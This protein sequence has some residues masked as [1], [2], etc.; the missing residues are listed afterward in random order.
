M[1]KIIITLLSVIVLASCSAPKYSYNFD[2]HNY[3]AGKKS[4][5]AEV[6]ESP[7]AVDPATLTASVEAQL[8]VLAEASAVSA[9]PKTFAQLSKTERKQVRKEIKKEIK[10]YVAAKKENRPTT[11]QASKAGMDNDLKLAAIFGAVGIVGLI[12]GGN[13]FWIIGGIAMLIGVVFFV[14][15]LIRQ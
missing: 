7:L 15:W 3:Y 2:H 9:A 1:K 6:A 11:V 13:V 8:V 14:K 4:K 5:A 12:I 10:K